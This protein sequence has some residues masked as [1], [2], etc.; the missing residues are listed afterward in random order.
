MDITDK[1]FD[2]DDIFEEDNQSEIIEDFFS[3]QDPVDFVCDAIVERSKTENMALDNIVMESI[4]LGHDVTDNSLEIN[5]LE[6]ELL[7]I[8]QTDIKVIFKNNL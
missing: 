4:M 5:E 1:A 6:N 7:G 2:Y 3:R 8:K